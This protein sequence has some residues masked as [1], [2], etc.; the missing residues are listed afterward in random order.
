MLEYFVHIDP[1][2]APDDLVLVK[3]EIPD[4]VPRILTSVKQLPKTW[5]Q[6]PSPPDFAAIGDEFVKR[7][8]ATVL[9][10]PSALAPAESNWL[11]N[12]LHAGFSKIR[13]HPAE[14]FAYDQRLIAR[15]K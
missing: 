6:L 11:I 8:R 13:V 3:A 10:V 9:V 7:S 14:P 4:S 1:D 2:N 15:S 12:P 5:R